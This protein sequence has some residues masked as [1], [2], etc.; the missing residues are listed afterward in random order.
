[1]AQTWAQSCAW[2]HGQPALDTEPPFSVIGQNLYMA[3]G[4]VGRPLDLTRAVQLWYDEKADYD[5]DTMRCVAGKMCG[6]YTQVR[7]MQVFNVQS[8]V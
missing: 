7:H 5:Y 2:K 8:H 3:T 4:R 1:M 6:H